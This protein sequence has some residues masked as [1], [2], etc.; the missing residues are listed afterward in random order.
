[1]ARASCRVLEMCSETLGRTD[2]SEQAGKFH[3][4][5]RRHHHKQIFNVS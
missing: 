1:M 4:H 2:V 5:R 3:R